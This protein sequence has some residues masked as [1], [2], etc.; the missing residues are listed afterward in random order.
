[1]G[2][3]TINEIK[4]MASIL[5]KTKVLGTNNINEIASLMI[6]ANENNASFTDYDIILGRVALKSQAVIKRFQNAGGKIKYIEMSDTKC[7]IEFSHED[8]GSITIDW[9]M[10]R[11]AQAGLNLNKQN[12]KQYPR[13]MLRARCLAEGVRALFPA[14]LDG[15]YLKEEVQDFNN[16]KTSK[17]E[18]NDNNNIDNSTY[19]INKNVYINYD[20]CPIGNNQGKM[21][22]DLDITT[23]SKALDYFTNKNIDKNYSE[24]I[25][26]ELE[27]KLS[28]NDDG[29]FWADMPTAELEK[30]YKDYKSGKLI[31]YAE[32]RANYIEKILLD[33]QTINNDIVKEL[34]TQDIT[35]SEDENPFEDEDGDY[36]DNYSED[37]PKEEGGLI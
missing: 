9:D 25:E 14:C 3:Y 22:K 11:A 10:K 12:W 13:Q 29:K 7:I 32:E 21:W 35:V 33:R 17:K 5:S 24:V 31:G 23:L 2:R 26:I 16:D 30:Y 27:K 20:V 4:E 18:N 19:D 1:M 34:K 36:F 37:E 28:V 8:A 15:L 6:I